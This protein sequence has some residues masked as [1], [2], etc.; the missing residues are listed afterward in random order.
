VNQSS[1][2]KKE[3]KPY[4]EREETFKLKIDEKEFKSNII[5]ESVVKKF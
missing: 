4:S 1:A 3:I 2:S 5:K